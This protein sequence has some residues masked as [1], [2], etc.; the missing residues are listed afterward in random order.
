[1]HFRQQPLRY[2]SVRMARHG[3]PYVRG[4]ENP[5][6]MRQIVAQPRAMQP[7]RHAA[8]APLMSAQQRAIRAERAR[9]AQPSRYAASASSLDSQQAMAADAAFSR[10]NQWPQQQPQGCHGQCGKYGINL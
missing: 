10:V 5:Y 9:Y 1:M 2:P 3:T 7:P 8:P 6:A 4:G